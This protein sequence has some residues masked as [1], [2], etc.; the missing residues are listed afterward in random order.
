[1][2]DEKLAQ[3]FCSRII[4]QSTDFYISTKTRRLR[5]NIQRLQK[6]ADSIGLIL[7][8]K[9]YSAAAANQSTLDLNPAYTASNANIEVRERDKIM[10]STVYTETVKNLESSKT[11]LAQETPTVQ[12]VDEPELP[13]KKNHLKYSVAILSGVLLSGLLF[14]FYI[15]F[16]RK[17]D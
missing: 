2:K 12:I 1:M 13:L 8:R 14:S 7:N 9:T 3:L 4:S 5:D 6:R 15:L 16:K 11:M 10:L 17:K